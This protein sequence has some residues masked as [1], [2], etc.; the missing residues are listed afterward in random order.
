MYLPL[1]S[2][3]TVPLGGG[4]GPAEG[5]DVLVLVGGRLTVPL[6][7]PVVELGV[8]AVDLLMGSTLAAGSSTMIVLGDEAAAPVGDGDGERVDL[9]RR[10]TGGGGVPAAALGV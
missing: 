9:R 2:T 5:Q 1:A 6:T 8:P 10:A 7:M 3:T 4:L